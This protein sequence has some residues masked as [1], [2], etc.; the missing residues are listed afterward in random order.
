M[1][2]ARR[3]FPKECE[4]R[5]SKYLMWSLPR[6][7]LLP[8]FHTDKL[9]TAATWMEVF[10]RPIKG[11]WPKQKRYES[12]SSVNAKSTR[13]ALAPTTSIY[14]PLAQVWPNIH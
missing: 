5:T 4:T 2:F 1:S 10:G 9:G 3:T 8:I 12:S 11:C 7:L 6:P 14:F 13:R